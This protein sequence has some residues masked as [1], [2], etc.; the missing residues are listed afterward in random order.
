MERKRKAEEE[1]IRGNDYLKAKDIDQAIECYDKAINLDP[2]NSALFC[3]RALARLNKKQFAKV[4]EDCNEALQLNPSYAKAYLRRG[5]ANKALKRFEEA[6]KDFSKVLEF[7]PE[8][9]SAVLD[10]QHCRKELEGKFTKVQIV[11]EDDEDSDES[12]AEA[13]AVD[14]TVQEIQNAAEHQVNS[15]LHEAQVP[16]TQLTDYDEATKELIGEAN[17]LRQAGNDLYQKG[18]YEK[19]IQKYEEAMEQLI[20][21]SFSDMSTINQLKASVLNNIATCYMQMSQPDKVVELA[22][23]ALY[24]TEADNL[25]KLKALLRRGLAYERL[26]KFRLAKQ[27]MLIVKQLDPANMQ[28]S[29]ALHRLSSVLIQDS[30]KEALEAQQQRQKLITELNELKIQGNAKYKQGEMDLAILEYTAGIDRIKAL[31]EIEIAS[32]PELRNLLVFLAVNRAAANLN[33]GCNVLVIKDAQLALKYDEENPKA[34][35]RLAK[36]FSNCNKYDEAIL[37]YHKVIQLMPEDQLVTKELA[38]LQV[39]MQESL[40]ASAQEHAGKRKKSVSFKD[41]TDLQQV[42]EEVKAVPPTTKPKPEAKKV[43]RDVV[44]NAA[45]RALELATTQD[46]AKN[47]SAFESAAHGMRNLPHSGFQNYLKSHTPKYLCELFARAQLSSE[48]FSQIIQAML[49]D[50]GL[51]SNWALSL[52]KD[53]PSTFKF[54]LTVKFLSK[55]E[56]SAVNELVARLNLSEEES[57]SLLSSLHILSK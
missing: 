53:L 13:S 11:E 18:S 38:D 33:L 35:Y 3:N 24:Y 34:N 50:T 12:E 51:D 48:V 29:Q 52:L 26:E 49:N 28:A 19:A 47:A 5:K 16:L 15:S 40:Q 44:D 46:N 36:A 6:A 21:I 43:D 9:A 25:T 23:S 56:K 27:D 10:L 42:I 1:K 45:K 8:E 14:N 4:I 30:Q 54:S 7:E 32:S 22:T 31:P 2:T 55:A 57:T 20:N 17:N 37:H 41:A 39:R